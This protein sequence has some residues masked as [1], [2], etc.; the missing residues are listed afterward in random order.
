MYH[1]S[2]ISNRLNT[3]TPLNTQFALN[4]LN[5]SNTWK[6]EVNFCTVGVCYAEFVHMRGFLTLIC[7]AQI[8]LSISLNKLVDKFDKIQ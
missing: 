6:S 1:K 2:N 5:T 8:C 7:Q 4:T 3:L